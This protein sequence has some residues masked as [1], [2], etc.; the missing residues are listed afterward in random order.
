MAGVE[1]LGLA[2]DLLQARREVRLGPARR[3]GAR[4]AASGTSRGSRGGLRSPARARSGRCRA[5]PS[6]RSS[7]GAR[8]GSAG[9]ARSTKAQRS[10]SPPSS[11]QD[12]T[13]MSGAA[14]WA[15]SIFRASCRGGRLAVRDEGGVAADDLGDDG[16]LGGLAF[17]DE[18]AELALAGRRMG[19]GS[20][21]EMRGHVWVERRGGVG[22]NETGPTT[23]Y[24]GGDRRRRGRQGSSWRCGGAACSAGGDRRGGEERRLPRRCGLPMPSGRSVGPHGKNGSAL[25]PGQVRPTGGPRPPAERRSGTVRRTS[26]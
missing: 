25:L 3:D 14:V 15:S 11:S 23:D 1:L 12:R 9:A 10:A 17:D 7:R 22:G 20:G 4:G 26:T 24:L 8:P 19:G 21:N 6:G 13:M 2:G 16:P 5:A 18:D